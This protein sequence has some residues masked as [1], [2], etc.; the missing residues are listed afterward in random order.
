MLIL[1]N[2]SSSPYTKLDELTLHFPG[3]STH[4]IFGLIYPCGYNPKFSLNH[5]H[6]LALGCVHSPPFIYKIQ[7]LWTRIYPPGCDRSQV[8]DAST[9]PQQ[10]RIAI[11]T[12]E[13]STLSQKLII[14]PRRT[15]PRVE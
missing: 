8:A 9:H 15:K 6:S 11:A 13:L 1:L 3:A 7:G 12:A 2:L 5:L 14:W 4:P 10:Y